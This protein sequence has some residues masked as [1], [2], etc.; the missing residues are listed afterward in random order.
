MPGLYFHSI[1]SRHQANNASCFAAFR[2]T[3]AQRTSGSGGGAA[4]SDAKSSDWFVAEEDVEVAAEP[5]KGSN[6]DFGAV[7]SKLISEF[8]LLNNNLSVYIRYLLGAT[9]RI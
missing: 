4:G 6:T 2:K 1:W 8:L 7:I 9:F 5:R 3:E